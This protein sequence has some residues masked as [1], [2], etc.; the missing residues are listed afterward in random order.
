[1]LDK[2]EDIEIENPTNYDFSNQE[3]D[4]EVKEITEIIKIRN[5]NA[6]NNESNSNRKYFFCECRGDEFHAIC[7]SCAMECHNNHKSYE[8]SCDEYFICYCG[9]SQHATVTLYKPDS[10]SSNNVRHNNFDSVSPPSYCTFNYLHNHTK[11]SGF[12]LIKKKN[13]TVCS[14]CFDNC[15]TKSQKQG[16]V[17]YLKSND[18]LTCKC[19]N[20]FE[21]N[22]FNICR[23]FFI[24]LKNSHNHFNNLNF[25][26]FQ[27]CE[28]TLEKFFKYVEKQIEE[29]SLEECYNLRITKISDFFSNFFISQI[30]KLFSMMNSNKLNRYFYLNE[31]IFN[32]HK[33]KEI[34]L[35]MLYSDRGNFSKDFP[36]HLIKTYSFSKIYF[37]EILFSYFFAKYISNN[38]SKINL[39]TFTNLN[40]FQRILYL[41]QSRNF[42]K[43]QKVDIDEKFIENYANTLIVLYTNLSRLNSESEN[44]DSLQII[45][46]KFNKIFKHFIKFN[47]IDEVTK[48][49]FFTVIHDSLI[50]KKGTFERVKCLYEN[51]RKSSFYIIKS[52]FY[53]MILKNDTIILQQLHSQGSSSEKGFIFLSNEESDLYSFIFGAIV[54]RVRRNE[55]VKD[56]EISGLTKFDFYVKKIFELLL[57]NE[58]KNFY[59]NS[60]ENLNYENEFL[61][62][63]NIP[64]KGLDSNIFHSDNYYNYYNYYSTKSN[65]SHESYIDKLLETLNSNAQKVKILQTVNLFVKNLNTTIEEFQNYDVNSSDFIFKANSIFSEFSQFFKVF[66]THFPDMNKEYFDCFDLEDV[67]D[68]NNLRRLKMIQE[69]VALCAPLFKALDKFFSIYAREKNFIKPEEKVILKKEN[70]EFILIFLQ[71]CIRGNYPNLVLFMSISPKD[72][73]TTFSFSDAHTHFLRF[74]NLLGDMLFKFRQ[75][76]YKLDN[77]WF[78][79]RLCMALCENISLTSISL[80][81]DD[82]SSTCSILEN[83]GNFF[84]ICK[85]PIR[86]LCVD[87]NEISL[88]LEVAKKKLLEIK[89]SNH[90]HV[91]N[92]LLKYFEDDASQYYHKN[93]TDPLKTAVYSFIL[94]YFEFIIEILDSD[95]FFFNLLNE[96]EHFIFTSEVLLNHLKKYFSDFSKDSVESFNTLSKSEKSQFHLI[97]TI[98]EAYMK[99]KFNFVFKNSTA[100]TENVIK[101]LYTKYNS[102]GK[103]ID[104]SGK[105]F[106][107]NDRNISLIHLNDNATATSKDNEIKEAD[108]K[109]SIYLAELN[110]EKS[111]LMFNIITLYEICCLNKITSK[112]EN[113]LVFRYFNNLIVKPFYILINH[114]LLKENEL[115]AEESSKIYELVRKFLGNSLKL[116][117][118]VAEVSEEIKNS[119]DEVFEHEGLVIKSK[120]T[121]I[122]TESLKHHLDKLERTIRYFELEKII[123]VYK[124]CLGLILRSN[125]SKNSKNSSPKSSENEMLVFKKISAIS[126]DYFNTFK[127]M[128]ERNSSLIKILSYNTGDVNK[129]ISREIFTYLNFKLNENLS[130]I[131][132]NSKYTNRVFANIKKIEDDLKFENFYILSIIKHLLKLDQD[133]FYYFFIDVNSLKN[134]YLFLVKYFLFNNLLHQCKSNY[135]IKNGFE[136]GISNRASYEISKICIKIVTMLCRN[137]EVQKFLYEMFIPANKEIVKN[138]IRVKLEERKTKLVPSLGNSVEEKKYF[139][140][141]KDSSANAKETR[142]RRQSLKFFE[143]MKTK[144]KKNMNVN[145]LINCFKRDHLSVIDEDTKNFLETRKYSFLNFLFMQLKILVNSLHLQETSLLYNFHDRYS[146]HTLLKIFEDLFSLINQ[147][148]I[149]TQRENFNFFYKKIPNMILEEKYFENS[150]YFIFL[151]YANEIKDLNFSN[152]NLSDR[153]AISIKTSVFV[154]LNSLTSQDLDENDSLILLSQSLF[155]FEELLNLAS[156]YLRALYVKH[157]QGISYK[158]K[159]FLEYFEQLNLNADIFVELTDEYIR[160]FKFSADPYF[161]LA[162]QIYMFITIMSEKYH[163]TKAKDCRNVA[164]LDLVRTSDSKNLLNNK[165]NVGDCKAMGNLGEKCLKEQILHKPVV[166]SYNDN[167][168]ELKEINSNFEENITDEKT[169][170][171]LNAVTYSNVPD[172]VNNLIITSR[173]F[174]EFI[175]SCEFVLSDPSSSNQKD[176]LKTVFF[177]INPSAFLVSDNSIQ[178]FYEEVDRSSANSKLKGLLNHLP[179]F[180]SEI[181]YRKYLITNSKHASNFNID[182]KN[183]D[184]INLII[185]FI[186]VV[187]LML[188]FSYLSDKTSLV[189]NFVVYPLTLIEIVINLISLFIFY[190][191]KKD[192]Y[193]ILLHNN[194]K[195]NI[196]ID[197]SKEI[198]PSPEGSFL[199]RIKLQLLDTFLWTEETYIITLNTLIAVTVLISPRFTFLFTLQLF[200]ILRFVKIMKQIVHAFK[201]RFG[202]FITMIIFLAILSNSYAMFSFYLIPGEFNLTLGDNST[203]N[204]CQTLLSCY[205][206]FFNYGVSSGGGIGDILTKR[207]LNDGGVYWI[208]YFLDLIFYISVILIILNMINGI[209]ICAFSAIRDENEIKYEDIHGKCFI[210]SISKFEFEKRKVDFNYHVKYE[211]NYIRYINYLLGLTLKEKENICSDDNY[212][213]DCL[214]TKDIKFFP[215][216]RSVSLG[217]FEENEDGDDCED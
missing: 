122:E 155:N 52:L 87:N 151:K 25:N 69:C 173:F 58:R 108:T 44:A 127:S 71:I 208:R 91:Y 109:Y 153:R 215:I 70:L 74:V 32:L 136:S 214:K 60:L 75:L 101:L 156:K 104:E 148:I 54:N 38:L 176:K 14:V 134:F 37:A 170:R 66:L 3:T 110:E 147:M 34:L 158:N 157:C 47:L 111:Q 57:L 120:L 152:G 204:V 98:S 191:W 199:N 13:L 84:K 131:N 201:M 117:E 10:K 160:N 55:I 166:N 211:H 78:Y 185:G 196:K 162:S 142:D 48:K 107:L 177:L 144:K 165:K 217:H 128:N 207:S 31:N 179:I 45:F 132:D 39:S 168:Q 64:L 192:F 180:K 16:E 145:S 62:N 210:C 164:D 163:K 193:M 88:V 40:L 4:F 28:L 41:H 67:G 161:K 154:I 200:T 92:I 72:F 65:S 53:A 86:A 17:T 83:L 138:P 116:Y 85:K 21:K 33:Y 89:K 63:T 61:I 80:N 51:P 119:I 30:L 73:V 169:R 56:K 102:R 123:K 121:Q 141:Y 205:M 178:Q 49:K 8:F 27:K 130:S 105:F 129:Q 206:T 59:A 114:Y 203:E 95:A 190:Y 90:L 133:K 24:L 96:D 118:F 22:S 113:L 100:M 159:K 149:G 187:V 23:D 183:I 42:I 202:Q 103:I 112:K 46:E 77:F 175:H 11:H 97:A 50:T 137:E 167:Y 94:N 140:F 195:S 143:N 79:V 124:E 188:S 12:Y 146:Y 182:Y 15:V 82:N 135:E 20:H 18:I 6:K 2:T 125:E 139:S 19:E 93:I 5:C 197:N 115:K 212:I 150:E 184:L 198:I 194:T 81:S 9:K 181:V 126:N 29:I 76:K 216:G 68:E 35:E 186:M 7:E 26:I 171:N 189:Y 1:M 213:M 99:L 174:N 209:V 106:Y 172:P 36:K 43:A